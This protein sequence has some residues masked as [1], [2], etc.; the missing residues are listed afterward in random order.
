MG[1]SALRV[2]VRSAALDRL[3]PVT[4]PDNEDSPKGEDRINPKSPEE[5]AALARELGVSSYHLS[6]VIS[7]VG[8]VLSDIYHALGLRAWEIPKRAAKPEQ[9]DPP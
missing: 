8:P 3:C 2:G 6:K 1:L 4:G 7:R 9:S 5:V